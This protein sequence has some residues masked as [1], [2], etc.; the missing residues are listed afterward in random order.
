MQAVNCAQYLLQSLGSLRRTKE[1]KGK[2]SVIG[3]KDTANEIAHA[4]GAN[5][6]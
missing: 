3:R 1:G 4:E 5:A 2:L 6:D